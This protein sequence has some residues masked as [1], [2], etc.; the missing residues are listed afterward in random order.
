M[1]GGAAEA[2]IGD[3]NKGNIHNLEHKDTALPHHLHMGHGYVCVHVCHRLFIKNG[4]EADRVQAS[5]FTGM[6]RLHMITIQKER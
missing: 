4:G 2:G 3:E 6:L 1:V 5:C